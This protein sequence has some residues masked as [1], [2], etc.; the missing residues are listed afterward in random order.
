MRSLGQTCLGQMSPDWL[1]TNGS[2]KFWSTGDGSELVPV[3]KKLGRPFHNTASP[4]I[5]LWDVGCCNGHSKMCYH[6]NAVGPS[7]LDPYKNS[8]VPFG[9]VQD[10]Y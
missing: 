3:R 8:C 9:I 7:M 4:G 6:T 10:G 1:D 2:G 5:F